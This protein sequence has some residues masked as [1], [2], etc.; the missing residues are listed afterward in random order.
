MSE[1]AVRT[2]SPHTATA[3]FRNPDGPPINLAD[4]K[5]VKATMKIGKKKTG[6]TEEG[7]PIYAPDGVVTG[8]GEGVVAKVHDNA[9][10]AFIN[11]IN[12]DDEATKNVDMI[13]TLHDTGSEEETS[14]ILKSVSFWTLPLGF[15]E[16]DINNKKI[17]FT[18]QKMEVA[19]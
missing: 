18:F 9:A 8:E 19:H 13:L 6:E 10:K 5:E 11:Y 12:G 7:Y 3:Y 16:D 2:I 15:K 14:V 4:L 17:E 1:E